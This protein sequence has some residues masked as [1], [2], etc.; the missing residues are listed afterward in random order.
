[1]VRVI[2]KDVDR[3]GGGRSV[4][5]HRDIYEI[6][7]IAR[8]VRVDAQ[9]LSAG[10]VMHIVGDVAGGRFVEQRGQVDLVSLSLVV[11][12][13][14]ILDVQL[15]VIKLER[16]GARATRK[17]VGPRAADEQVVAC[18]AGEGVVTGSAA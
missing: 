9:R 2:V 1:M 17:R 11:V 6:G 18:P 15:K 12:G 10:V 3:A 14:E 5:Q 4:L 8:T 7:R 16:I 13:N